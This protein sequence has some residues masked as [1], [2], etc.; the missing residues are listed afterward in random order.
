MVM[1]V[2]HCRPAAEHAPDLPI[3]AFLF[4]LNKEPS[5][6]SGFVVV[7]VVVDDVDVVVGMDST[8]A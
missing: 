2:S 8:F 1:S 4:K 3:P 6:S 7:V 5:S